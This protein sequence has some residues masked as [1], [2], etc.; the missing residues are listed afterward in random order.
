MKSNSPDP[1]AFLVICL[2]G[3]ACCSNPDVNQRSSGEPVFVI[4]PKGYENTL[5]T[6]V[7]TSAK[8]AS[9]WLGSLGKNGYTTDLQSHRQPSFV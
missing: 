1:C 4:L 7:K 5:A 3:Q 8:Y 9:Q 2:A 6:Y